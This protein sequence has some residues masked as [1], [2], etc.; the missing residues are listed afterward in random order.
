VAFATQALLLRRIDFG[1]SDLVV[2]LLTPRT[3]RISAIAKGAR[4][5][6][7]RFPG[8]LDFFNLLQVEIAPVR[9]S[10][11]LARLEHARLVHSFARL[12][13]D[14]ARFALASYLLE[15]LGRLAPEGGAAVDLKR[16]F[17]FA[18]AELRDADA[19]APDAKRRT[20]VELR[21]L[22]AL[23]L[24]PELVRCVRCERPL[25]GEG[26]V[27]FHVGEGGPL[28]PGCGAGVAGL[29]PVHLGT[30][31]SLE[32]GLRLDP[33]RLGRLALAPATLAEARELVSRFQRFHLGLELRSQ[34]FLDGILA[35][36]APPA[37]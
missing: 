34:R 18:L 30:L 11:A 25:A 1:E 19:S 5:S 9:R 10:G 4:R 6:T 8:T 7:R 17:E 31:R 14:P 2:H 26:R 23:G 22:H 15:L 21:A 13:T 33:E 12:R 37:A 20:F 35:G 24:C 32:R 36:A 28:C 27:G 29:L 16:L 3:G